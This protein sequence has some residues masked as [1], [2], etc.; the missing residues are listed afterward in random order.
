[1]M[2]IMKFVT[3][4]VSIS[5]DYVFQD[6]GIVLERKPTEKVMS[7][8]E[9]PLNY[10]IIY[11]H[12]KI[13]L[14]NEKNINECGLTPK[15]ANKY[16]ADYES[17]IENQWNNILKGAEENVTKVSR[18]AKRGIISSLI[19]ST[20][21]SL[22]AMFSVTHYF[23]PGFYHYNDSIHQNTI[24]LDKHTQMFKTIIAEEEMHQKR[25][26]SVICDLYR[27][28]NFFAL[29]N[30]LQSRAKLIEQDILIG[31]TDRLPLS[32]KTVRDIFNICLD[33]QEMRTDHNAQIV[34]EICHSWS[35]HQTRAIFKGATDDKDG[36]IQLKFEIYVPVLD[37]DNPIRISY[38]VKNIGFFKN[39]QK[40]KFVV[41]NEVFRLGQA[42]ELYD[43]RCV[44]SIC[45]H[46]DPIVDACLTEIRLNETVKSC[47][48]VKMEQPC[49][50]T[51]FRQGY[52]VSFKGTYRENRATKL[53][54]HAGNHLVKA[55]QIYCY[56]NTFLELLPRAPLNYSRIV[57]FSVHRISLDEIRFIGNSSA[58]TKIEKQVSEI[59]DLGI[60]LVSNSSTFMYVLLSF[61]ILL[62]AGFAILAIKIFVLTDK[63]NVIVS[64]PKPEALEFNRPTLK[65]RPKS[66]LF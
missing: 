9:I 38:D 13:L 17:K 47:N 22:L 58:Q 55:G 41:P 6:A 36:N 28:V 56:D 53:V 43:L 45:R 15:K 50:V 18:R 46:W 8:Y 31:A 26:Q 19:G 5:A 30:Y 27:E 35:I 1:M 7:H 23:Q 25:A 62:T 57:T 37:L 12:P 64:R 11:R 21:G 40:F 24:K 14:L 63:T 39:E 32:P 44:N 16:F 29:N 52:L 59:N 4:I 20:L 60:N 10:I 51:P 61:N 2:N 66:T 34:R 48:A 3:L 49:T 65:K 54:A 33:T 42:N